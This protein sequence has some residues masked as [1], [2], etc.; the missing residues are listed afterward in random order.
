MFLE[1]AVQHVG[2][3]AMASGYGRDGGCGLLAGRYQFGFELAGIGAVS[4]PGGISGKV[5]VFEHDVHDGL[6]ARDLARCQSSIQDGLAGRLRFK[7]ISGGRV[8]RS[9][10]SQWSHSL[11]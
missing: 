5:G 3:H 8:R 7:A 1:P 4:T 2:V 11:P 10:Q 9:V 6:R